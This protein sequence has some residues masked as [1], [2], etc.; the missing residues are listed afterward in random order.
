MFASI[1]KFFTPTPVP[2]V[3][4]RE[5]AEWAV[6]AT[7]IDPELGV[8]LVSLG[9]IRDVILE[10]DHA[11]VRMTLTTPSCPVAPVIVKQVKDAMAT[12]GWVADVKLE[13]D[14]PWSPDDMSTSARMA[15]KARG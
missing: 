6:L 10:G 8:D 11:F 15:L 13:F 1:R 4:T 3:P 14:P 12:R 7:V 5:G 9:M 2:P